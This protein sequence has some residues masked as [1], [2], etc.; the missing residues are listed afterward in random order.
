MSCNA[1]RCRNAPSPAAGSTAPATG[2]LPT[3][4][5]AVAIP[6]NGVT[7][8]SAA[9]RPMRPRPRKVFDNDIATSFIFD[10]AKRIAWPAPV[11]THFRAPDPPSGHW[12][13]VVFCPQTIDAIHQLSANEN[14]LDAPDDAHR[15]SAG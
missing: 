10:L 3:T 5:S 1:R 12:A 4:L 15:F 6:P 2:A 14:T 13:H 8:S 11:C 9:A 7:A